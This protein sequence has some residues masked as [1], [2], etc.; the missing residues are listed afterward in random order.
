MNRQRIIP[1]CESV[2]P[3]SLKSDCT[4]VYRIMCSGGE[5]SIAAVNFADCV[6][7][8]GDFS[9]NVR[10][11]HLFKRNRCC[12]LRRIGIED[13]A[14]R[15]CISH[16]AHF[17]GN[18]D[19][20]DIFAVWLYVERFGI[21]RPVISNSSFQCRVRFIGGVRYEIFRFCYA[22]FIINSIYRHRLGVL[23]EQTEGD[24]IEEGGPLVFAKLD[25]RRR[26]CFVQ[27]HAFDRY[28]LV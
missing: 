28:G 25:F 19:V 11:S 8:E 2:E 17:V 12:F 16:I 6:A 15:A 26:H 23:E 1:G 4:A 20:N 18:L 9:G 13:N 10:C 5:Q 27:R 24:F 14:I 3:A 22:G 7:F 21:D